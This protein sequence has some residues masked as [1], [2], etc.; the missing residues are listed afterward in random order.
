MS[1]ILEIWNRDGV[2][3][4]HGEWRA[5]VST[6]PNQPPFPARKPSWFD[7]GAFRP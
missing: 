6:S 3:D 5:V 4:K 2:Q 7:G 1:G